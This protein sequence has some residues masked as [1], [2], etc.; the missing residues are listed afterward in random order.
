[1]KEIKLLGVTLDVFPQSTNRGWRSTLQT[2]QL[3]DLLDTLAEDHPGKSDEG[4]AKLA[5]ALIYEAYPDFET[6]A[7]Y[8]HSQTLQLCGHVTVSE[9]V[10]ADAAAATLSVSHTGWTVRSL[11]GAAASCDPTVRRWS[12][13]LQPAN[14]VIGQVLLKKPCSPKENYD[15][16]N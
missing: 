4:L 9:S 11:Q 8:I 3:E 16:T 6:V 13:I 7:V 2:S 12:I 1:M 10:I 5:E 15:G 14:V